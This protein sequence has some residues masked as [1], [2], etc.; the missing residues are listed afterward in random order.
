MKTDP[1]PQRPLAPKAF[2]LKLDRKDLPKL[3]DLVRSFR[4]DLK[5]LENL[6][7]PDSVYQCSVAAFPVYKPEL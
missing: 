6:N 2:T 1:Q 3:K 7:S 5:D 4:K